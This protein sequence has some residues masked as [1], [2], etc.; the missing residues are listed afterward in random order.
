MASSE[1]K[2]EVT[3]SVVTDELLFDGGK[4]FWPLD[5]DGNVT[6]VVPNEVTFG[7][8]K[9]WNKDYTVKLNRVP[10]STIIFA[11]GYGFKKGTNDSA[12]K[13][14]YFKLDGKDDK[15][16]ADNKGYLLNDKGQKIE[17]PASTVTAEKDAGI[18]ARLAQYAT[19]LFG[20]GGGGKSLTDHEVELRRVVKTMLEERG[21]DSAVIKKVELKPVLGFNLMIARTCKTEDFKPDSEKGKA[22]FKKN[23]DYIDGVV[24]TNLANRTTLMEATI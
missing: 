3:E 5:D 13:D 4:D 22:L 7:I 14:K 8:T 6:I 20:G 11:L 15:R 16:K 10:V 18:R 24:K 19:G 21:F 9:P 23:W 2:V 1:K 17:R 12:A